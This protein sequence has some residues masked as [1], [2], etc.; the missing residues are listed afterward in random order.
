MRNVKI[1]TFTTLYP[2]AA[3]PRHGLFV[4][5]RLRQLLHTGELTARV[6]APVPWFPLRAA[7]FGRYAK[8]AAV[9]ASEERHGINVGHPRYLTL[10][11]IGMNVAPWF[12]AHAASAWLRET[13]ADFDLIDAH[14][15]YP[16]GVAAAL[17]GRR[18]AK[19]VV[20]TARGSDVNLIPQYRWPRHL[21]RW[22]AAR[23]AA[24]VTVSQALK[25][26]L[27]RLGVGA[28]KIAVLRNGVDLDLF[29]PLDRAVARAELGLRKR[30]LLCVGNL[31]RSKGQ[32]L[33]IEALIHLPDTE[34]LIVG[35]G[36]DRH[37]FEA[38]ARSV[39][40]ATRV[41]FVGGVPQEDLAR[42][43]SAADA[44]VL[45]SEREGWPNVLLESLACGTPVVASRVGGAAE[46]VCAPE[47]GILV[48]RRSVAAFA[49]A[50]GRLFAEPPDRDTTRRYA[51]GFGWDETAR[52][53]TALYRRV[54][55][56]N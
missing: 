44:L 55:G 51:E 9:P 2:N 52:A 36:P 56:A 16:D 14:Y 6:V 1:L 24:I 29:R 4:E 33:A 11:K 49:Q 45:A 48:A 26:E 30:T 18:L 10:P 42:Y 25:D 34:L 20:I 17:I 32:D 43:Y 54:I 38:L 13:R 40:V 46:I 3:Q 28:S 12:L 5:Q 21:I 19:P 50:L 35:E 39:N 53:Q 8:Y 7:R 15:F 27:V 22:A 41:R 31:L 23:A 47:A 37:R